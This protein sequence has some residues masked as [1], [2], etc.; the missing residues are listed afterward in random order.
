MTAVSRPRSAPV[1]GVRLQPW[2]GAQARDRLDDVMR[3]Y[4]RA[5][6]DVHERDP[7]RAERDRRGHVATHLARPDVHV[8]AAL[9]PADR[10][11]A[12]TYSVPG[13]TGTWWHDV[14]SGALA[15]DVRADWMT[16]VIEV[17]ELHVLPEAQGHG[18]GRALLRGLLGASTARTAALSALDDPSLPARHLYAAE[19]F[20]P[21]LEDFAFPGSTT[22][23]A[24]LG[25]RLR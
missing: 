1:P 21:L 15:T 17:V 13:R 24:V 11:V 10:L 9:D 8:L 5:F 22:R 6:L 12:V 18:L 2:T 3:V 4:R 23:Y 19:G 14:V 25:K 20:A 16:D 7:A